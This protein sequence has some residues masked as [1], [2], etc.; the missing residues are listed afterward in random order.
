MA[1][2]EPTSRLE[3]VNVI[4]SALGQAPVST[5][6]GNSS[7]TVAKAKAILDE[8]SRAIQSEG[9]KFNTEED[10]TL[11]RDV[12]NKIA[13]PLNTLQVDPDDISKDYVQRGQYLYDA[14][15]HVD[16]FDGNVKVTIVFYF[17]F[18]SL[19][20]VARRYISVVTAR[21]FHRRERKDQQ[22]EI[23]TE[24]EELT[25]R[26]NMD[27]QYARNAD[28]TLLSHDTVRGYRRP[29]LRR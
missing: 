24:R 15:K 26:S 7:T 18:E 27:R 20:E 14:K 16:T 19:P 4:L 3:A 2:L 5:L 1:S 9:W 17:D 13:L 22:Q 25:A 23:I 11:V 10:Y 6:E 28:F 29:V 12:N 21:T 8:F